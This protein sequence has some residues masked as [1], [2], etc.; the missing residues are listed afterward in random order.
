MSLLTWTLGQLL[1]IAFCVALVIG[2]RIAVDALHLFHQ[3]GLARIRRS[4]R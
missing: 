1:G 3:A 2:L 4:T